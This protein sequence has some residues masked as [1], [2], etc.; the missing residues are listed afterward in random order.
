MRNFSNWWLLPAWERHAFLR[1]MLL[2]P[3]AWLGLRVCGFAWTSRWA[4][5][6]PSPSRATRFSGMSQPELVEVAQ[7]FATLTEIASRR[8]LYRANCLHQ[9]LTLCRLLRSYGIAAQLRVGVRKHQ[10]TLD[11]HAWVELD[12]KVIGEPVRD[13]VAFEALSSTQKPAP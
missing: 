6:A 1:L 10:E 2:L 3:F 12:G 7:R 8:G 9:S 11:A 4:E 13:Y 5:R